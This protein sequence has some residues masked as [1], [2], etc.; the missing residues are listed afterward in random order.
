MIV[1]LYVETNLIMGIAK[2]RDIEAQNLLLNTPASVSIIVP[3]ICF[4]EA[5]MTLMQEGKYNKLFFDS[6]NIQIT[7]AERDK[8]SEN[9]Q[10]LYARLQQ[11][12]VSFQK[13]IDD[14][15]QRFDFAYNQLVNIAEEIPLQLAAI[16]DGLQR[17]VLQEKHLMD[18][19]ILECIIQHARLRPDETKVFLSS[20]TQEFGKREVSDIFRDAG[21]L[22]FSKTQNFLGWLQSQ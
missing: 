3:S 19:V 15:K 21:I 12:L 9:A 8:T 4:F 16:Q 2:G 22:Y 1:I 14:T 11:S 18:K 10:L 5:K 6:L 17:N 20:N 7:E 13:R